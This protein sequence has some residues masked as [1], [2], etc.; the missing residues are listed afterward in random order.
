MA[1]YSGEPRNRMFVK[2]YELLSVGKTMGKNIVKN[3][4]KTLSGKY[5]QK[6]FDHAKLF[7]TDVPKASSKRVIKKTAGATG[8]QTGNKTANKI[9][10]VSKNSQQNNLETVTNENDKEI[11]KEKCISPE[12]RQ[13]IID[14]QRLKQH[15]NGI[16]KNHKSFKKFTAK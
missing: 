12:E 10:K 3:I 2:G 9:S 7:A 6:P 16:S 8:D 14:E 15:N 5:S 1:R 13:E 11:T 4:S